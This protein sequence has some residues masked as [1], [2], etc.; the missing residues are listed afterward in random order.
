MRAI[1]RGNRAR[2]RRAI[3]AAYLACAVA[4]ALLA[5]WAPTGTATAQASASSRAAPAAGLPRGTHSHARGPI[6]SRGPSLTMAPDNA[7]GLS[8]PI[9][10]VSG[11]GWVAGE[12]V[13]LYL[14]SEFGATLLATVTAV[15][16]GTWSAGDVAL[17]GWLATISAQPSECTGVYN[18][19]SGTS[20]TGCEYQLSAMASP[21]FGQTGEAAGTFYLDANPGDQPVSFPNEGTSETVTGTTS[22]GCATG[23]PPPGGQPK[24]APRLPLGISGRWIIDA[25]G[26]RFKLAS[27]NWY[28]AEEADFVPSGLECQPLSAIANQLLALGVNSVRLPWSNAMEELAPVSCTKTTPNP[29][30]ASPWQPGEEC[31][32]PE[33]LAANPGLIGDTALK[34]FEKVITALARDGITVILDDH[35][36]DAAWSFSPYDG[37]WWAGKI[38]DDRYGLG[39]AWKARTRMWESDWVSLLQ[40]L[41]TGLSKAAYAHIIGAD[42]R[43]E[44]SF[45]PAYSG[46]PAAQWPTGT[47]RPAA[48]APG[49]TCRSPFSTSTSPAN[50]VAAAEE[51][52]DSVLCA[53]RSLLVMVEGVKYST[54]FNATVSGSNGN[55]TCSSNATVAPVV[56]DTSSKVVYSPHSYPPAI[57]KNQNTETET[58]TQ[59]SCMLGDQWGFLLTQGHPYTAPVWVGEFGASAAKAPQFTVAT[60]G[61]CA[62]RDS[63]SSCDITTSDNGPWLNCFLNYLNSNDAD[64]SYWAVNGTQADQGIAK[65]HRLQGSLQIPQ[66]LL[67]PESYGILGP[68]WNTAAPNLSEDLASVGPATQGPGSWTPSEAP[69]PGN[70]GTSPSGA[71][72]RG[73]TCGGAGSCTAVGDYTDTAGDPQALIETLS[74]GSWTPAEAPMPANAASEPL[75]QLD[76]V[77]CPAAGMCV[78]TGDYTDANGSEDGLIETLSG[79]AWTAAE[80]PLPANALA[81]PSA[82]LQSVAC[83]AAG[84]CVAAGTYTTAG[85]GVSP[86]QGL[87]E[88]L[89]GGT[90]TAAEAPLP[91]GAASEPLAELRSVACPA[92]GTCT[93]VGRYNDAN[94]DQ[95]GRIESLSGGSWTPTSAPLP[96]DSASPA[97]AALYSVSCPAA[98]AC[99]AVGGYEQSVSGTQGLTETLSGGTWAPAAMTAQPGNTGQDPHLLAVTCLAPRSC[100][101]IGDYTDTNGFGQGM[102][103]T[104]SGRT[105]TAAQAPVPANAYADPNALFNSVA[106]PAVGSCLITGSFT[107]ASRNSPGLIESQNPPAPR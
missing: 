12:T 57:P 62:Q 66:T 61:N 52:G 13:D 23:A 90:W 101:A 49:G 104:L 44:P 107:D 73:I 91:V 77:A 46:Q 39:A 74:G 54:C 27:V 42:L 53:D 93:A 31:V 37:L 50:W 94:G 99:T 70:A 41:G 18:D 100:T 85:S 71:T 16:D 106:C 58:Y 38:W 69:M 26:D 81:A 1:R 103:D 82:Q 22:S 56:L 14:D 3:V 21:G 97:S 19:D 36:T 20:V 65:D 86:D 28:G 47:A 6:V 15:A 24:L 33:A 67:N 80:A 29:Y 60:S 34:V 5:A 96:A 10:V 45:V 75:A 25:N 4:A 102:I 55:L 84:T 79:G 59:L 68:S 48:P 17:P 88:T 51:G 11:S 87:I 35:S 92:P 105:W 2:Y 32:P 76:S 83:P 64:W 7:A 40:I 8:P 43:N 9:L 95:A 63:G 30:P 89:S 98:A 72:L 78:A